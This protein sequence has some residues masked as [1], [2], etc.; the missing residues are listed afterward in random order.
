MSDIH[1]FVESHKSVIHSFKT[2]D[3]FKIHY[4]FF[5]MILAQSNVDHYARECEFGILK[6]K[7]TKKKQEKSFGCV[8]D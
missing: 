7:Q 3:C 1:V 8:L 4:I 2:Q 5:F 6:K